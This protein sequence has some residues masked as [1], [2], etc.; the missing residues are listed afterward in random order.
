MRY[1]ISSR[2]INYLK[3]IL[4]RDPEEPINRIYEAQVEKPCP[5]NFAVLVAKDLEMIGDPKNT[6]IIKN[7]ANEVFKRSVKNRIKTA[8]FKYLKI[9]Q[10]EHSKVK[11]INY[12]SL[13]TQPYLKSE[14]FTNR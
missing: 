14:M 4:N 7:A 3:S 11:N 1:I 5:G 2:R 8:A 6:T 13:E 9:K 12:T 10:M